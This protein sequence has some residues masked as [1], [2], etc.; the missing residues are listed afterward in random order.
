MRIEC[1]VDVRWH[2]W[3]RGF[4]SRC[5]PGRSG[6]EVLWNSPALEWLVVGHQSCRL[7]ERIS[8]PFDASAA[9][10]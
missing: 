5:W 3:D 8:R 7:T 9:V 4:S 10:A 1:V 2:K 6:R